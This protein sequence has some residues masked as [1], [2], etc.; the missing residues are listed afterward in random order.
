M[1][2]VNSIL[3]N[4]ISIYDATENVKVGFIKNVLNFVQNVVLSSSSGTE[5]SDN[6]NDLNIVEEEGPPKVKRGNKTC[7]T[8]VKS[9]ILSKVNLT[10]REI[11]QKNSQNW[12]NP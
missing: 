2:V 3:Q 5:N 12:K 1:P 6:E 4:P 8:A 11:L 9:I 7:F 10:N